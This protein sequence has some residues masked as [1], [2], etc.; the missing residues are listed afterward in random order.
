M[1]STLSISDEGM[2][3]R[4]TTPLPLRGHQP[5]AVHQH[6]RRGRAE[7]AQVDVG[8]PVVAGVVRGARVGRDELRQRVERGLDR[9][10]PTAPEE[11]LG[12]R[13][14]RAR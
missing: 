3:L 14:D 2:M 4:S 5:L 10:R 13:D 6:Q 7:A 12:D 1:I 8:L 11:V 9:A